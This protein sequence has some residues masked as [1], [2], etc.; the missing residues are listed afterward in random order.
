V[1]RIAL[2]AIVLAACG[3]KKHHDK[4]AGSAST[5]AGSAGSASGP[6]FPVDWTKCEAALREA[7]TAPLDNRPELVIEGC[8]VCGDWTPILKWN[9]P[10]G[11]GGP[12]RQLITSAME[13]CNAFCNSQAKQHFL[14]TLDDARGTPSRAPWRYLGEVCKAGVSA[15]PDKR[16]MSAPLFA[17]D[18]IARAAVAH[19]GQAATLAQAILLPLPAISVT[20]A[21]IV[22]P[23]VESDLAPTAGPIAITITG[24]QM[25]IAKLPTARMT[26]TG[27][28]VDLG[29]YPGD[30]VKLDGLQAALTKLA[31]TTPS[32]VTIL[33]P[34]A[35]PAETLVPIVAI[36]S[37][38]AQTYLG[39]NAANTPEGWDL[40]GNI[41]VAVDAPPGKPAKD[42]VK[43]SHEATA[44]DLANELATRAKAGAKK[45][46]LAT[47]K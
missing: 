18:R 31:D 29:N 22:I 21:G 40:P 33:A 2:L 41:A 45:A 30:A 36:A 14:G 6:V 3:G 4:G 44:Q 34:T 39:A 19:G 26:A 38:V 15:L 13:R 9:T 5:S 23:D 43:L 20:G 12:T 11:S 8:Q 24:G 17:L 46:S 28:A 37:K 1:T 7:S 10:E 42:A 25:Y 16:F 27:L 35:T 32:S 47:S